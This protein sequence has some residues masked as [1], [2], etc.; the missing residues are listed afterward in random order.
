MNGEAKLTQLA[1]LIVCPLLQLVRGPPI[2]HTSTVKVVEQLHNVTTHIFIL[3]N[4]IH[5]TWSKTTIMDFSTVII[6][7]PAYDYFYDTSTW[8]LGLGG[9]MDSST[10]MIPP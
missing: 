1:A 10:V 8:D 3:E 4:T 5:Y 9:I 7:G 2:R 6:V